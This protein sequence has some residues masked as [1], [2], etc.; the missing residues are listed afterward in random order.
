MTSHRVN[1]SAMSSPPFQCQSSGAS[2]VTLLA[3]LVPTAKQDDDGLTATYEVQAVA[4]TIMNTHLGDPAAHGCDVP[5]VAH[6]NVSQ[7]SVDTSDCAPVPQASDPPLERG[8]FD[9]LNHMHAYY[10]LQH[11]V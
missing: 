2:D 3:A 11:L 8:A 7:T 9:Y 10:R 4:R 5:E 1:L 6:R